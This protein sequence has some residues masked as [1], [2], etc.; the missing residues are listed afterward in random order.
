MNRYSAS[1]RFKRE[2][3]S[4]LTDLCFA[5]MFCLALG[6][7]AYALGSFDWFIGAGLVASALASF[8]SPPLIF[9][10][11]PGI[12]LLVRWVRRVVNAEGADVGSLS[13][14]RS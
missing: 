8:S 10:A 2:S 4:H 13:A 11:T 14:N 1:A 5:V 9:P 6:F 7:A 3:R 12:N